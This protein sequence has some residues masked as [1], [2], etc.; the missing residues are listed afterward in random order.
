MQAPKRTREMTAPKARDMTARGKREARRPWLPKSK[1]HGALKGRN[2]YF[3]PSDLY[4]VSVCLTRGDVPTKS[5]LAPCFYIPRLRRSCLRFFLAILL[6]ARRILW[7][8]VRGL[9]SF[10]PA[11]KQR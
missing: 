10:V 8:T 11:A 3:G 4:R 7:Q 6:A 5:E 2:K 1:I 9:R